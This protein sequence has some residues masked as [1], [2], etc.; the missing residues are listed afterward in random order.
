V[1]KEE[2]TTTTTTKIITGDTPNRKERTATYRL[3][4]NQTQPILM[5]KV[6]LT[7]TPAQALK[8]VFHNEH[9]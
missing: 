5:Q 7:K 6:S 8:R 9:M 3:L 4:R 1:H 2:T